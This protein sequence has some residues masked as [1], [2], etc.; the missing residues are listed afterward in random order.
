MKHLQPRVSTVNWT[1]LWRKPGQVNRF[2]NGF[3]SNGTVIIDGSDFPECCRHECGIWVTELACGSATEPDKSLVLQ[4][5]GI[6]ALREM[7][8][9][10]LYPETCTSDKKGEKYV[11]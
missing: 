5:C 7:Q 4:S 1:R 6:P 11:V 8:H 9:L 3:A 10:A 2:G